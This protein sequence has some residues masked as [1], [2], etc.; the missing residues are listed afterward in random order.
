MKTQLETLKERGLIAQES[1]QNKISDYLES[2]AKTFYVGFDPTGDSL[3]VGHLAAILCI[4][5]LISFG[6]KAIC[7]VG[8]GTAIIGDPSNKTEMRKMMTA[9]QIEHNRLSL[10]AQMSKLL[11]L[12]DVTFLNNADWLL[13]L[14]Y[15]EFMRDYGIHFKVNEMIKNDIYKNRL[16]REDGLTVFELNYLLLQSYDYLYLYKKYNCTVQIGGS[17]QWSNILGGVDLIKKVEKKEVYAL[18]WPLIARSDGK[19]MGKSES[20]AVW[21]NSEKT[22]PY[23]FYQYWLNVPDTDVERFFK[24][25]TFL[26]IE[27]IENI[28]TNDIREAKKVLAYEV[29]AYIHGADEANKA[30]ESSE[31]LFGGKDAA[32]EN[33]EEHL[34]L[35]SD[36][37][38]D[39]VNVIDI[40]IK[41]GATKSKR[42]ARDLVSS[43]GVYVDGVKTEDTEILLTDK[44]SFLLRVGKKKYFKIVLS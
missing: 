3:H 9:E 39:K 35:K 27:N 25:F 24:V 23:E 40:M 44:E 4:H 18:T 29:T 6:H 41:I 1:H 42:E 11:K 16:D 19:K 36:F 30:R 2:G 31:V 8:G 17:D 32:L 21:L 10:A 13:S 37:K 22:G 38:N 28:M 5:R 15:L 20:G 43:G 14:N 34:F 12:N 33:F 26:E 7:I